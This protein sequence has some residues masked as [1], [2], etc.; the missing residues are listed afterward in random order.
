MAMRGLGVGV[1]MVVLAAV[2]GASAP[3]LAAEV[4]CSSEDGD[5]TVSNDDGDS[6]SCACGDKGQ[7]T[8][9]GNEWEDLSEDELMEICEMELAFCGGGSSD[10]EMT[11]TIG[12]DT[13]VMDTGSSVGTDTEPMDTGTTVTVTDTDAESGTTD[14]TET[15]DSGSTGD[16]GDTGDTGSS[17]DASAGS[18]EDAT[19]EDASASNADADASATN[20]D[21]DAS[22]TNAEESSEGDGGAE[23]GDGDSGCSCNTAGRDRSGLLG[24]GLLGLLGLRAQRR[25]E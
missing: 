12:T 1:A 5:C 17:G 15:G 21:A 13:D 18:S 4:M 9:G 6:V 7:G 14:H 22:A 2:W 23:G 11:T 8:T 10:T 3:A 19:A 20:A 24:L 25:R 16:T